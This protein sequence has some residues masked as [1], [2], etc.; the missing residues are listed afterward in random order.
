[1]LRDGGPYPSTR[2]DDIITVEVQARLQTLDLMPE[3]V[4]KP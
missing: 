3:G 1:M 2:F 4:K